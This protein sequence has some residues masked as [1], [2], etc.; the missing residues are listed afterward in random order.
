VVG[1]AMDVTVVVGEAM[2][3]TAVVVITGAHGALVNVPF[4]AM[5]KQQNETYHFT[6]THANAQN[7]F[8]QPYRS[9]IY[10]AI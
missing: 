4:F 10:A 9:T 3:V 1:E 6:H 8:I 5:N 7:I 2:D